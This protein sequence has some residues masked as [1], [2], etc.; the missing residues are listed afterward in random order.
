MNDIHSAFDFLFIPTRA[1]KKLYIFMKKVE[2]K[3]SKKRKKQT[4][5]MK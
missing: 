3:I 2:E 5:N 1:E 4:S